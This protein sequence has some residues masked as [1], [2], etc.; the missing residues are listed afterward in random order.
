MEKSVNQSWTI[1]V[2]VKIEKKKKKEYTTEL[3]RDM[4]EIRRNPLKF[5]AELANKKWEDIWEMSLEEAVKYWNKE[6]QVTL[7]KLAPYKEVQIKTG[8]PRVNLPIEATEMIKEKKKNRLKHSRNK[9]ERK[10]LKRKLKDL[11]KR[12]RKII[13]EHKWSH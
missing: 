6:I 12:C 7:D 9:E 2:E 1:S 5:Q 10:I 8:K 3:K 11:K 4:K 13:E